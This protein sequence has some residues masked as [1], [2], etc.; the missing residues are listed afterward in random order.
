MGE[1][2][3]RPEA[4]GEVL[5][6]QNG[7]NHFV[8]SSNDRRP[9]TIAAVGRGHIEQLPFVVNMHGV[10]STEHFDVVVVVPVLQSVD[11]FGPG[12]FT[13]GGEVPGHENAPVVAAHG[14]V[15]QRRRLLGK[16]PL[17]GKG[18]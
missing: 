17:G 10:G 11:G 8:G 15:V 5:K 18:L 13:G 16:A 4:S 1:A 7:L 14:L 12:L 9:G 6:F 2:K 3:H